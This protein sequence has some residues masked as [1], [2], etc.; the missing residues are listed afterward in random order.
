MA[1]CK[2]CPGKLKKLWKQV[3]DKLVANVGISL[4]ITNKLR[5][6]LSSDVAIVITDIIP[7]SLDDVIRIQAVKALSVVSHELGLIDNTNKLLHESVLSTVSALQNMTPVNAENAL[8]KI[9]SKITEKIDGRYK[10]H[11]YDLATQAVYSLNKVE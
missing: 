2:G 11:M 4:E 10:G 6:W 7:G 1:F 9:A 3:D 5:Q 8:S